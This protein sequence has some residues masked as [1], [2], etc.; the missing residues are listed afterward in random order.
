[1]NTVK[2]YSDTRGTLMFPIK[3]NKH[4]NNIECNLKECTYSIN[5]KNV[6]RGL[7]INTFSKIITCISGSFIDIIVKFRYLYS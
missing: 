6:F 1:M 4:G 5:H 3:N 7:H 2:T